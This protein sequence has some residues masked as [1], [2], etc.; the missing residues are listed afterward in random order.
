MLQEISKALTN[1]GLSGVLKFGE[2]IKKREEE[3]GGSV[4]NNKYPE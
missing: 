2:D 3:K 4:E 1:I